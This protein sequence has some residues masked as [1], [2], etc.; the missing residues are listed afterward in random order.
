MNLRRI[1]RK[2][3]TVSEERVRSK[4]KFLAKTFWGPIVLHSDFHSISNR[5]RDEDNA[6]ER[7]NRSNCYSESNQNTSRVVFYFATVRLGGGLGCGM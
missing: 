4:E 5:H 2:K 6:D 3:R 1:E 7:T